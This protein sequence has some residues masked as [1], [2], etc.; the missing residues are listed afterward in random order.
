MSLAGI[1]APRAIAGRAPQT[2]RRG[3]CAGTDAGLLQ[4]RC[5]GVAG[6]SLGCGL[7][8][9]TVAI[10]LVDQVPDAHCVEFPHP[11]S[12]AYWASA[13]GR[14]VRNKYREW[15]DDNIEPSHV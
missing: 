3:D 2:R 11:I 4:K 14:M 8:D 5:T 15:F 1:A 10:E 7:L 9:G 13:A 12:A 6:G